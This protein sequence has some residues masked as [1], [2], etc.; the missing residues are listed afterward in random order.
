MYLLHNPTGERETFTTTS[1]VNHS[2]VICSLQ[3]EAW[4]YCL[5]EDP[6]AAVNLPGHEIQRYNELVDEG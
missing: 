5:E 3:K 6:A 2:P 1:T 4:Q